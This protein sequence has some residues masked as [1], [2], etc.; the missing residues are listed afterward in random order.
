MFRVHFRALM[1]YFVGLAGVAA[2]V[3]VLWMIIDA[4]HPE[5]RLL[6]IRA[7]KAE[8]AE[9]VGDAARSDI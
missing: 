7:L 8:R 4:K 9:A 3:S 2:V 1:L 5:Q 6:K